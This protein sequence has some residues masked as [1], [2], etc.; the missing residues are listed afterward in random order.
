MLLYFTRPI[1][2]KFL[3]IG[4]ETTNAN[5]LIGKIGIV[6]L[7]IEPLKNYGQ[8]KV[9]GQIWSAKSA[10][11]VDIDK[12]KKVIIKE[13]QGVKLVVEPIEEETTN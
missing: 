13:I 6:L 1:A 3:K 4:K 10:N 5:S 2:I 8:V 9:N 12:D 11:G 7:P